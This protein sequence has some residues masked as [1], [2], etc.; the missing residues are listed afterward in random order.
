MSWNKNQDNNWQ[1]QE[2]E[3]ARQRYAES[4]WILN[5]LR[6][7]TGTPTAPAANEEI[8]LWN[9]QVNANPD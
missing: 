9:K 3:E 8:V 6:T 1:A 5:I 2:L 4:E 7:Q